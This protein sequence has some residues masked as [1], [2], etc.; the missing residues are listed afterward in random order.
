MT[1]TLS[2]IT[3]KNCVAYP[4]GALNLDDTCS[5]DGACVLEYVNISN[6]VVTEHIVYAGVGCTVTDCTGVNTFDYEQNVGSC[7]GVTWNLWPINVTGDDV[8]VAH[9]GTT[10]LSFDGGGQTFDNVGISGADAFA[11]TIVG[12]NT[13]AG[14]FHIDASATEKTIKFTDGTTTAVGGMTRDAGRNWITLT[15]TS[16]AGWAIVNSGSGD[17]NLHRMK[18]YYSAAS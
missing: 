13:L 7:E 5:I 6:A 4:V 10:D 2:N 3:L 18:V 9:D 11:L 12:S 1:V 14:I 15:G 8:A 16:T 17:V